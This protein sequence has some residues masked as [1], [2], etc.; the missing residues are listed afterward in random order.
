MWRYAAAVAGG[1]CEAVMMNNP[2]WTFI[3]SQLGAQAPTLLV[4]LVGLILAGIWWRRAPAAAMYA[5][6]GCG[7]LLLTSV[8]TTVGH[9]YI[10]TTRGAGPTPAT[11]IAQ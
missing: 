6:I 3:F 4:Y 9:A 1:Y 2:Q 10:I 11:S 7:I 5:M 8:A